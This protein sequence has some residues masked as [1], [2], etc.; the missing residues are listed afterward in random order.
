MHLRELAP[1]T[2]DAQVWRGFDH[3]LALG[4]GSLLLVPVG[5]V[6]AGDLR[7]VRDGCP[8]PWRE[9]WAV[10]D[11]PLSGAVAV[12]PQS[13]ACELPRL[14]RATSAYGWQRDRLTPDPGHGVRAQ[15]W[16]NANGVRF[17]RLDGK[18]EAARW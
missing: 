18:R 13:M 1:F 4:V 9:V 3:L 2:A 12:S 10:I 6:T 5:L 8:V 14:V 11:V 17:V 16:V 7:A 15:R